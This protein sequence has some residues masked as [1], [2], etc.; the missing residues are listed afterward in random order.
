MSPKIEIS[1][2]GTEKRA[3]PMITVNTV[4]ENVL[5]I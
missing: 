1:N 3:C 5:V 2:C 4:L